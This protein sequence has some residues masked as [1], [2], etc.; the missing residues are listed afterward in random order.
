MFDLIAKTW[1]GKTIGRIL[2]EREVVRHCGN[3]AGKVIDIAGG[4]Y[5]GYEK[6]LS[7]NIQLVRTNWQPG[8]GVDLVVDANLRLPF[9]DGEWATALC[10]NALYILEDPERFLKDLHRVLAPG[11]MLYLSSPFLG[12]EMAEPHDYQRFTAEGLQ[13]LFHRAGFADI[14]I[15]RYGERATTSAYLLHPFFRWNF[16]RVPVH[17]LAVL[18][19]R[20]IPSKTLSIHPAPIGYFVLA[21]KGN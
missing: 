1:R 15:H 9:S 4:P 7:P 20:L 5:P 3:I 12:N 17:V 19:D 14:V 8:E 18:L 13:R 11:G 10:F 16:V 6:Y 2:F 21:K